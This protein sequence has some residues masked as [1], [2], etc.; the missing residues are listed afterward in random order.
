MFRIF[1]TVL[2]S[3]VVFSLIFAPVICCC[4]SKSAHAAQTSQ[5]PHCKLHHSQ[6]NHSSQE[7]QCECPKLQGTLAKQNFDIIK[8]AD[9][10]LSFL[11]EKTILAQDFL[12]VIP[13]N[14]HLLAE[15]SPPEL[16]LNSIPLYI[17]NSVL[18]I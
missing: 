4:L 11:N 9:I 18:R 5:S 7:H 6:K 16:P 15:H 17:K 2:I 3:P 14:H 10:I 12:S 13:N 8:S 1:K